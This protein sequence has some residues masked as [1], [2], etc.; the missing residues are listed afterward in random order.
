M[1][2]VRHHAIVLIDKVAQV[3][4]QSKTG[5]MILPHKFLFMQYNLQY[6]PVISIGSDAHEDFPDMEIG[7]IAVFHHSVESIG[8]HLL[9][10]GIEDN[11]EV[12]YRSVRVTADEVE[13]QVYAILKQ[14]GRFIA[15]PHWIFL[16]P[17][18][19]SARIPFPVPEGVTAGDASI[20]QDEK[21][22]VRAMDE[23]RV[24]TDIMERTLDLSKDLAKRIEIRNQTNELRKHR[25]K[26]SAF[27]N[28]EKMITGT[29]LHVHPSVSE[30]IGIQP[31]N[32][33]LVTHSDG[34]IPLSLSDDDGIQ[35]YCLAMTQY[36]VGTY[37]II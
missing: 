21:F 19:K 14:D 8:T 20:Y 35:M 23:L 36:V 26:I 11:T 15:H 16:A 4:L 37:H 31:G 18:I 10:T 7:D 1:I 2:A 12:E 6:G 9:D 24:Q 30:S 5:T 3:D 32:N 27:I 22:L 33:A 17:D 25:D 29:V 34:L 13:N 28:S